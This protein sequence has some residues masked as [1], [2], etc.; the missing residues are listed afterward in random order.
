MSQDDPD[1]YASTRAGKVLP[2]D[3]ACKQARQSTVYGI[4][5]HINF[6]QSTK[7]TELASLAGNEQFARAR[8]ARLI[9]SNEIPA[10]MTDEMSP[11]CIHYP[12]V[13]S[14]ET[15]RALA[16]RHPNMRYQVGR[17][18]A[19]AGYARLYREL[20]LLPDVS[21]AEEA[22]ENYDN[23]GAQEIFARIMAAPVRYRVLDDYTLTVNA[24]R[25]EVPASLN[26]ETAVVGSSGNRSHLRQYYL[27]SGSGFDI[28]ED[29][30]M[31]A[32]H[33]ELKSQTDQ[34][35]LAPHEIVLLH[36]PLPFDLPTMQK[37]T[38]TLC[39]A[40]RGDIDRWNRLRGRRTWPLRLESTCL[41][42]GCQFNTSMAVWLSQSPQVLDAVGITHW[43]SREPIKRAIHARFLMDDSIQ[44]LLDP[45][46]VPD[47]ELP[48]WIW[49]P[50]LPR[51]ELVEALARARLAM[52]PQCVRTCIVA[53]WQG[54]FDTIMALGPADA[55]WLD[56]AVMDEAG[57]S[58]NP[59][60]LRDLDGR[61]QERGYGVPPVWE[62][63]DEWKLCTPATD[64]NCRDMDDKGVQEL[65]RELSDSWKQLDPGLGMEY[66]SEHWFWEGVG[67]ATRKVDRYLTATEEEREGVRRQWD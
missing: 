48:Y 57:R 60:Y 35:T 45:A 67:C 11:Y 1:K 54:L 63:P 61:V 47:D 41:A 38:L 30:S 4:R 20:D 66:P 31:G 37:T 5:H 26:A 2:Q 18:C 17:A 52:L 34:P 14:E 40:Y 65:H 3:L 27:A 53:N 59:H 22:R 10:A 29:G 39:A 12:D 28:T 32:N 8:N 19:V 6:A 42:H 23:A 49:Y 15:Y 58:P 21:I 36:S 64:A 50:D 33:P 25:P 43:S 7:V 9:M 46:V 56:R 13:A 16:K 55:P 24:D 62:T 51:A 44:S